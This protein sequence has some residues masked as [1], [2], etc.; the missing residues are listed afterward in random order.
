V[1]VLRRLATTI[2][3]LA[4]T[5]PR[6]LVAIDGSDA[7]GKTTL[8]GSLAGLVRAPVIQA[9]IDDFQH[10]Q[11]IR[12]RLGDLSPQGYYLDGFDHD[13]LAS[14]L[15][16]PFIEGAAVV[17]TASF[18]YDLDQPAPVSVEVPARA[19]LLVDGVF[20]QVESIR[21]FW[22]LAVYLAVSPEVAFRRG[23]D[24]DANGV[25]EGSVEVVSHRYA[26]RYLPAQALYRAEVDPEGSADILVDN[27]NP[28]DPAVLRWNQPRM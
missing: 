9:S 6:V 8:A 22:S 2:D 21:R 7:A 17:Q 15:L 4:T 23:V 18:D 5:R 14:T 20:L 19:V 24:R 11:A 1:D 10:S 3:E 26:V 12:R 13:T 27:T 16:A 28:A 25:G